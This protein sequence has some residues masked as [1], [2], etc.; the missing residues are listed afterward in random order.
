MPTVSPGRRAGGFTSEVFEKDMQSEAYR[1][2]TSMHT[3]KTTSDFF[4]HYNLRR[5]V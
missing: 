3:R 4:P 2:K 1:T 5:S